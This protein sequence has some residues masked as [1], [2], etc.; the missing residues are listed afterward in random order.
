MAKVG[1]ID[2]NIYSLI[3]SNSEELELENRADKK[4][5]GSRYM[6][7]IV[8]HGL[9]LGERHEDNDDDDQT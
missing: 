9:E 1:W 4:C 3:L 5:A 7:R 8:E 6:A 2:K